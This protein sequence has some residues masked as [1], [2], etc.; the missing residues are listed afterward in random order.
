MPFLSVCSVSGG[1]HKICKK[2][3][4]AAVC[5]YTVA[6]SFAQ[7]LLFL[8][9]KVSFTRIF[10]VLKAHLSVSEDTQSTFQVIVLQPIIQAL[11]KLE[12]VSESL[13]SQET[14]I[15]Y[16]SAWQTAV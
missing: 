14:L 3:V 5:A 4:I 16:Y 2:N 7:S 15:R 1:S 9:R 8:F 12:A 11:S 6:L 13:K 10:L